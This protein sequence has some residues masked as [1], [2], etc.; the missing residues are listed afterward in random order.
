MKTLALFRDL[1]SKKAAE[2]GDGVIAALSPYFNIKIFTE[3]QCNRDTFNN[4]DML[5]FPGGVG[6][7]DDYDAMFFR[8]RAN[9]VADFVANGGAYLGICVGAYWAGRHYFDILDGV[10]AVQYIK[11]PTADI[12]KC[13]DVAAKIN[14]QGQEERIFFR[15]GCTFLGDKSKY[16]VTATYANGDP[17]CIVQVRIGLMGAC[18]DSLESW[19]NTPRLKPFW[20]QGRHHILLQDFV[21]ELLEK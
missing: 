3:A 19:Y 13:Y 12:R 17:M 8:K 7:A 6:D 14:W 9:A 15:D 11:R 18:P 2:C 10:D 21:K 4:V 16:S 20:H 5:V 1:S